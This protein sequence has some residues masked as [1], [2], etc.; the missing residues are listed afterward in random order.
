MRGFMGERHKT[1]GDRIYDLTGTE[2]A[3]VAVLA[4][5]IFWIGLGTSPFIQRMRPPLTWLEDRLEQVS[6]MA[7]G[8]ER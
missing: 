8:Q 1:L 6:G 7:S 2:R 4:V 5:L 3:I